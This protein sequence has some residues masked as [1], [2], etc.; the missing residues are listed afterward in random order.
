M[1]RII[2]YISNQI[3]RKNNVA[4][5]AGDVAELLRSNIH[6]AARHFFQV[7][8]LPKEGDMTREEQEDEDEDDGDDI[9]LLQFV[10]VLQVESKK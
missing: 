6:A 4:K 5:F 7:S 10:R 9:T 1:K 3:Y 8:R 2:L